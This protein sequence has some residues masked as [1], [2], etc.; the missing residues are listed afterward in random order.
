MEVLFPME[1]LAVRGYVEVIRHYL[2]IVGIRR[3]LARA[4]PGASRRRCSSASMRPIST[5]AWS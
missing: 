4:F 3:R 2:E 1:K 5:S